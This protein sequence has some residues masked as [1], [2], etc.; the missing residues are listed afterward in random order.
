MILIVADVHGAVTALRRTA[1]RGATLFVLGDLINFVD[2]RTYDG[3]VADVSGREFVGEMVRL[4]TAGAFEEAGSLWRRHAAGREDEL[5]RRYDELVVDAYE[6]I[7]GAL[8]GATSYVTYGNVDRPSV[9]RRHLP[10][11]A[12]FVDGEVVTIDGERFGFVGGGTVSL[13]TPGEVNE[14][15]M[16][17]K[18]AEL[19]DVDVLC[20]H[21]PPAIP[22]L[23]TDVIGGRQKGSASV[24]EYVQVHQP[25]LHYFGDIHQPQATTW[26]IGATVCRNA[27]YFR[28]TGRAIRHA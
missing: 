24:L 7:C 4:R 26:R 8:A 18:L 21:V 6:E 16:A 12:H 25:R 28:A 19:G 22:P 2:Y 17:D 11:E 20:T 1:A 23:A 27:G 14:A 10:P 13:G 3:L 9:L 15:D 5:I